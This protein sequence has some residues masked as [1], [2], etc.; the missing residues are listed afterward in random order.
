[1]VRVCGGRER[2]KGEGGRA[3]KNMPRAK[4]EVQIRYD[5][6]HASSRAPRVADNAQLNANGIPKALQRATRTHRVVEK[7]VRA[8][9]GGGRVEGDG[10][11]KKG[12]ARFDSERPERGGVGETQKVS[13]GQR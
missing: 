10:S 2:G 9:Q 3:G 5:T 1:M 12:N 13:V 6:L 7:R 11:N 8:K 4:R